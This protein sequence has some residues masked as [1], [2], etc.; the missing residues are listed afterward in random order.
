MEELK[1]L[2]EVIA[3]AAWF[4]YALAIGVL[5]LIILIPVLIYQRKRARQAEQS[6]DRKKAVPRWIAVAVLGIAVGLIGVFV[7]AVLTAG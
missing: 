4:Y 7:L 2:G 5:L 1:P 6:G 3:I